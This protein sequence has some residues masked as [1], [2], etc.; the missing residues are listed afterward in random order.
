MGP[1]PTNHT[2]LK[3][4]HVLLGARHLYQMIEMKLIPQYQ[5]DEDNMCL[6][7]LLF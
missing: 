1:N 2:A 7:F 6:C 3:P 5:Y 4:F